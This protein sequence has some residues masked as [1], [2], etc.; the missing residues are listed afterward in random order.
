MTVDR[1]VTLGCDLGVHMSGFD[2]TPVELQVCG[3]MLA[4][5]SDEL[6][7]ELT[8]LRAEMD[9]LFSTGWQG[10]AANGFAQG[11]DQWQTGA[12]DVLNALGDMASLLT[13]TGQNYASTDESSADGLRDS[14]VGL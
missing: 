2:A 14:G 11:W 9:G 7:G 12:H 6:H 3:S 13:T 5:I 8:T 10:Q 4:D 1:A